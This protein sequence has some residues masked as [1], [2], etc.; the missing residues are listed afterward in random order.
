MKIRRLLLLAAL[1]CIPI[2]IAATAGEP[3]TAHSAADEQIIREVVDKYFRGVVNADRELLEEA[4][5][6]G[7]TRMVFVSSLGLPEPKFDSVP[8]DVAMEWW[9]QVKATS[10]SGKILT[11]DIVEGEMALV[12]FDFRYEHMHF[13]DFLTLLK[14]KEGWKLVSKSF[15]RIMPDRAGAS[16]TKKD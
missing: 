8:I 14:L 1:T 12:K 6:V 13:I 15:V 2:V 10:S 16:P 4:W 3:T 11:I 9:T 7:G 5:H